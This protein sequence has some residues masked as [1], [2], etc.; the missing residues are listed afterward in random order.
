MTNVHDLYDSPRCTHAATTTGV[1][2]SLP[3]IYAEQ[4][5]EERGHGH[6]RA[7]DG[8][9]GD[10]RDYRGRGEDRDHR[11]EGSGWNNRGSGHNSDVVD[12]ERRAG[13]TH[14]GKGRA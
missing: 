9:D 6:P 12:N 1:F 4:L 2:S 14:R 7:G 8:G 13:T 5:R 11:G 3:E 10:G